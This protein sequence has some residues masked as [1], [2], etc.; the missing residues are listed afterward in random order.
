MKSK[1]IKKLFLIF[2]LALL[3]GGSL[4]LSSCSDYYMDHVRGN[5]LMDTEYRTMDYYNGIELQGA[6]DVFL[7]YDSSSEIRI[8]AE[9]NLIPYIE[10]YVRNETLVLTTLKNSNIRNR[11]TMKIFVPITEIR[12]IRLSGSGDIMGDSRFY[13]DIFELILSGS[14][15]VALDLDANEIDLKISGSGDIEMDNTCDLLT[16]RISG[17]GDIY[18]S[19]YA[20]KTEYYITGSGDVNALDMPCSTNKTYISGSGDV[21]VDVSDYLNVDIPGSGDVYYKGHPDIDVKITGSG[22]LIKL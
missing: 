20:D 21:W 19:G 4:I 9:S 22:D 2:S 1:S 7:T 17:S 15:D 18:L 12:N 14:G 8:E 10:T 13:S 6:F 3:S 11:L 5:G 16:S